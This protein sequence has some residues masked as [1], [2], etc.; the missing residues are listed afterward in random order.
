MQHIIHITRA[1]MTLRHRIHLQKVQS[2]PRKAVGREVRDAT[3]ERAVA[4]NV[5]VGHAILPED[6]LLESG[7]GL[8]QHAQAQ[9]LCPDG[10]VGDVLPQIF[11]IVVD[12]IQ[13]SR[14]AT[15]PLGF[16]VVCKTNDTMKRTYNTMHCN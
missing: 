1:C 8:A 12:A 11:D 7:L 13:A 2:I 10:L 9:R 5:R 4:V 3:Q 16:R 14:D 6:F 15:L